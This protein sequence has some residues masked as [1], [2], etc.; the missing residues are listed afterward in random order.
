MPFEI[1]RNDINGYTLPNQAELFA[2]K[3][4]TILT[5]S[6]LYAT[7]SQSSLDIFK[8]ELTIDSMVEGYMNIYKSIKE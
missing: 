1:V 8:K 7:M 6:E 4:D 2:E 3:I 5:N